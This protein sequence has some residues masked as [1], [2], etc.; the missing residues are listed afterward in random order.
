MSFDIP[1]QPVLANG[2]NGMFVVLFVII[3]IY[4]FISNLITE[5]KQAKKKQQKQGRRPQGDRGN[6]QGE[7]DDFLKEVLGGNAPQKPKPRPQQ[8]PKPKPKPNPQ[9]QRELDAEEETRRRRRFQ[10]TS[11]HVEQEPPRRQPERRPRPQPTPQ[12]RR[13]PKQRRPQPQKPATPTFADEEPKRKS[14]K[15]R[16]INSGVDDH[17]SSYMHGKPDNAIDL[18]A[19]PIPGSI[20]AAASPILEGKPKESEISDVA[21][22]MGELLRTPAGLQQAILANEILSKP[23]AL[24]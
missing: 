24:R 14:L 9:R 20:D 12:K 1:I 4:G 19:G 13:P 23:K 5:A 15:D 22:Q 11:A 7:I 2:F 16:H 21:L 17:V 6:L 10:E 8:K 18:D 3:A